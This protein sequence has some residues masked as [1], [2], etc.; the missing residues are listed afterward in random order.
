MLRIGLMILLGFSSLGAARAG[1]EGEQIPMTEGF[2]Q[3]GFE[4]IANT[5]GVSVFKD[6]RVEVI[7]LGAEG[8]FAAPPEIVQQ[9][10]LDYDHQVG[11]LDRLEKSRILDRGD[12]WL[13]VYQRLDLPVIDDRDFNLKVTWGETD[14]VRW[15]RWRTTPRGIG[16]QPGVV[17]VTDHSGSWQLAP[18]SDGQLTRARFQVRMDVAGLVP[19]WMARSG[20]G[21]EVPEVFMSVRRLL[22]ERVLFGAKPCKS[23]SC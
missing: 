22:V 8:R 14:G 9:T 3:V 10:L 1:P 15:I 12:H 2:A 13:I 16:P 6:E 18:I 11:K 20:A 7:R 19:K 4:A 23:N 17:R 5:N 21:D